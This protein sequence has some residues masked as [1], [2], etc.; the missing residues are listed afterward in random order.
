MHLRI[1]QVHENSAFSSDRI[2]ISPFPTN[3]ARMTA[4]WRRRRTTRMLRQGRCYNNRRKLF[5]TAGD[6]EGARSAAGDETQTTVSIIIVFDVCFRRRKKAE[7]VALRMS[8]EIKHLP[9]S[10]LA[11][12]YATHTFFVLPFNATFWPEEF[13]ARDCTNSAASKQTVHL[14]T[15]DDWLSGF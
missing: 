1:L 4:H 3:A 9:P 13:T 2:R 5:T 14:I 11:T 12:E 6:R 15:R 7:S 10:R 8:H